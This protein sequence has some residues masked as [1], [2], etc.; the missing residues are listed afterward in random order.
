MAVKVLSGKVFLLITGASQG[1][2]QQI[3]VTFS[4]LLSENSQILLFARNEKGLKETV[5]RIGK[6]TTVNYVS[7]D[8]SLAKANELTEIINK[9]VN[10][11]EYDRAVVVQNAGTIGDLSKSTVDMDDFDV[12]R[13]Y[14]DLNVFSPAV[15]NSVF[16]KIFNNV[17]T[18]KLVINITSKCGIVPF[19]SMGYYCSGK[20]AREMYFKV[21][22]DEFPL[23]N[24]L[25][26]SPGPVETGMLRTAS[27][28]ASDADTKEMF[29]TMRQ[30]KRQLTTEQTVNRLVQI[31][32]EQKYTSGDHIDYFDQI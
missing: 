2:G 16:M 14:Y 19:K 17:R 27:E 32:K 30:E 31:L 24:V 28:T 15:L 11:L 9:Y 7:I 10:P 29:T 18:E 5:E 8:L 23:V 6:N 13:K 21:F 20:A 25:N 1:I 26:Y 4:E 22:A 3:A 12:W